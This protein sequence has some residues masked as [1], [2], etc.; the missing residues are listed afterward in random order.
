MIQ[1]YW[2]EGTLRKNQREKACGTWTGSGN[3]Q[4]WSWL[5]WG[6]AHEE[7]CLGSSFLLYPDVNSIGQIAVCFENIHIR[8]IIEVF[9]LWAKIM[10]KFHIVY[11]RNQNCSLKPELVYIVLSFLP[12]LLLFHQRILVEIK[13]QK[14]LF[15]SENSPWMC[16]FS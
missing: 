15:L 4:P 3:C 7:M 11:G 8:I 10:S 13:K 1:T 2:G 16:T 9:Y 14:L 6:K 5:T 12:F